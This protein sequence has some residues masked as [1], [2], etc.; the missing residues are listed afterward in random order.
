MFLSLHVK[1]IVRLIRQKGISG[2]NRLPMTVFEPGCNTIK[3]QSRSGDDTMSSDRVE[4]MSS[5]WRPP[6][7][8][9]SL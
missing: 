3:M 6:K 1:E 4:F 7:S 5:Q 9:I 2:E 8:M